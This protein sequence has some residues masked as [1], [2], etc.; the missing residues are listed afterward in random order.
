MA[1]LR[2]GR[3]T[4][5]TLGGVVALLGCAAW[6][7]TAAAPAANVVKTTSGPV[8]GLTEGKVVSFRGI[9]YAQP[10]VGELRWRPPA[11]VKAWTTV[12][13]ATQFG[14]PCAQASAPGLNLIGGA[15]PSEDCLYLNVWKPA[16]AKA[17]AKLPVMVWIHG[18]AYQFGSGAL[19]TAAAA[20]FAKDGVILVSLNYRLGRLGQFAHPA[21]TAE[22]AGGPV[23]N[24]ALLD[25]IRGLHWVQDNVAGFGG[26]PKRVTLFGI[27]SGGGTINALTVSPMA[28]GLF[29]R[30]IPQSSNNFPAWRYLQRPDGAGGPSAEQAGAEWAAGAGASTAAQLRALPVDVI[31]KPPTRLERGGSVYIVDGKVLTE[32]VSDA[33]AAGRQNRVDYLTGAV[34]LEGTLISMFPLPLDLLLRRFGPAAEQARALYL[35]AGVPEKVATMNLYGDIAF[36]ASTLNLA[37][38]ASAAGQRTYLYHFD[39]VPEELRGQMPGA[40]HGGEYPFIFNSF[41]PATMPTGSYAPSEAD[42]A[43]AR[44]THAYWV[45]FA[46]TGDPNGRGLPA[47]PAYDAAKDQL[48]YFAPPAPAPRAGVLKERMQLTMPIALAGPAS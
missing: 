29:Q 48:L 21:L 20:E 46:M 14:A 24:Y 2:T 31:V 19:P 3:R 32:R 15:A 7:Q 12:R 16:G 18:G 26:D 6:T 43:M 40:A 25:I 23:A 42:R 17:G 27:S 4:L 38:K 36:V 5:A 30:A 35:P 44:T 37:Q 41:D 9:P 28:K 10:P 13:Q 39:Y 47:W 1:V 33:Y 8:A 22:S 45:N 11:P 34:S